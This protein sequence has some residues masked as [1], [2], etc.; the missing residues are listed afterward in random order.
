MNVLGGYHQGW[1]VVMAGMFKV[2]ICW[3]IKSADSISFPWPSCNL[4]NK[5]RIASL[6]Y[7]TFLGIIFHWKRK[8]G[9]NGYIR[10]ECALWSH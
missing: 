7:K 10:S 4:L 8:C 9:M 2:D 3:N 1:E 6:S 5:K